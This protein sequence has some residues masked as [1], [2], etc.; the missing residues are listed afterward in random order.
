MVA[1]G[2]VLEVS[3]QFRRNKAEQF[4]PELIWQF[5]VVGE[6]MCGASDPFLFLLPFP[7]EGRGWG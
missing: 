4:T 2:H 1:V 5:R 3:R 7:L 6:R